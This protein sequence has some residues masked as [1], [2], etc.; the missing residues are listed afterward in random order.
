MAKINMTLRGKMRHHKYQID[1]S[2]IHTVTWVRYLGSYMVGKC[3]EA[4]RPNGSASS[5]GS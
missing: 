5:I 4:D 3:I 2:F 1:F